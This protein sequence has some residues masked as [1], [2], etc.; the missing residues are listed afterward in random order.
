MPWFAWVIIG[1]AL[2]CVCVAAGVARWF[3]IQRRLDERG[4]RW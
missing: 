3:R 1:W 2:A 4:F